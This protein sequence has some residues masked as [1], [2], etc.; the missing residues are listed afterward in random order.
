MSI[1]DDDTTQAVSAP[2][3]KAASRQKNPFAD[4]DERLEPHIKDDTPFEDDE[5]DDEFTPLDSS[6]NRHLSRSLENIRD[7]GPAHATKTANTTET[8]S[9]PAKPETPPKAE[10]RNPFADN[11][12]NRQGPSD[13]HKKIDKSNNPFL[14]GVDTSKLTTQKTEKTAETKTGNAPQASKIK[15]PQPAK[16]APSEATISSKRDPQQT[17]LRATANTAAKP[18]RQPRP[19]S[20]EIPSREAPVQQPSSQRQAPPPPEF[21]RRQQPAI[22]V[23]NLTLWALLAMAVLLAAW[24]MIQLSGVEN[25]LVELTSEVTRLQQQPTSVDSNSEGSDLRLSRL[26]NNLQAVENRIQ[27]LQR[28]VAPAANNQPLKDEM[29]Q[30][31]QRVDQLQKQLQATTTAKQTPSPVAKAPAEAAPKPNGWVINIASLSNRGNALKL[32]G[33]ASALGADAKVEPY[34]SQGRTL[35]RIRAYGYNSQG[36]AEQA[37]IRLQNGLGVGG[38]IVRKID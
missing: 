7:H 30:L 36:A 9:Q 16:P 29:A 35:Y 25:R 33:K 12:S 23:G 11:Q 20:D 21:A 13:S 8:Q 2:K 4:P 6:R 22:G 1:F 15:A 34:P 24:S 10:S 28:P 27:K 5:L 19:Q 32:A 26:E 31:Q 38:L 17:N 3:S 18:P 37:A 14:A